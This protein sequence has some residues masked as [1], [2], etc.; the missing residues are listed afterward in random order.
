MSQLRVAT[1][2]LE[3]V[4]PRS[5]RKLPAQRAAMARVGADVWVLTETRTGV[6]P[7]EGF[8]PLHCPARDSGHHADDERMV[9]I[10]SR[11]PIEPTGLEPRARG[12]V[13]GVVESPFGRT[14]VF[15]SVIPYANAKGPDGTSRMWQEHYTEIERLAEEWTALAAEMPLIVAGDFNQDR[16]GSGWYGTKKGRAMLTDALDAAGMT[17]V[18]EAD[19]VANGRL[20][21]KHL[22]DHVCLTED[23]AARVRSVECWEAV[24]AA[25]IRMSDHPGVV[26]R[27]K[28]RVSPRSAGARTQ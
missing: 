14:A 15:G 5:W 23:L 28:T 13:S 11:W 20:R 24:D 25:G 12:A 18:T 21:T 22:I 9:S 27:L 17:C 6:S 7:G 16:D 1:W 8:H 4:S 2:N 10:W 19:M 26:V 3:R